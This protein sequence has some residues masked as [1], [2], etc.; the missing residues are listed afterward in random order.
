V[1]AKNG[2]LDTA[3]WRLGVPPALA[4]DKNLKRLSDPAYF[5]PNYGSVLDQATDLEIP[6]NAGL[7]PPVQHSIIQY[8][9][10]LPRD[11]A[12]FT[13]FLAVVASR[14]T[15]KTTTAALALSAKAM[16][17]PGTT[18]VTIADEQDRADVLFESVMYNYSRLPEAVRMPPINTTAVK[19]LRFPHG[20]SY[21]ALTSGFTGNTGLGRG[22]AWSHISEGPFHKNFAAFW[23]KYLP[24]VI[25]RKNA[26]VIVESTPGAMSEPSSPAY[27]ELMAEARQGLGRWAYVFAG[28]WTSR[29]NERPW[30]KD[31][32]L[33]LE[34]IRLLEL[35]GRKDGGSMSEPGNIHVMTLENLAFLREVRI[36][37]PEIRRDPS[38]LWV[39]YPK[40]DISCWHVVGN[41]AF[42]NHAMEALLVR[43]GGESSLIR[44]QPEDGMYQEYH[45]PRNDALY[46]IGVDPSGWGSGDPS[47]FQVLEV[48][49]DEVRQ[50]AE[51]DSNLL[52]PP[53]F[54]A[55]IIEVARYYNN[56]EVFVEN[57]GVGGAVLAVLE[58]AYDSKK[59]VN[60]FYYKKDRP[61]VPNTVPRHDEALAALVDASLDSRSGGRGTLVVR[62]VNLQAQLGTYR[63]DK[64]VQQGTKTLILKGTTTA[65]GRREKHHW[66]RVSALLWAMYGVQFQQSRTKPSFGPSR[67]VA[68]D[69]S[70][71]QAFRLGF[72]KHK[73]TYGALLTPKSKKRR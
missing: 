47:S 32:K 38:L 23:T 16:Y 19:H 8:C 25:N 24:A 73:K 9:S 57:N 56:A 72:S 14:Q 49:S 10:E 12:G 36:M 21:R 40:D 71:G 39:F 53:Q 51:F 43:S 59:L 50:V 7:C 27:R 48:W 18:G 35:Y 62:S 11:D 17:N 66:D 55:K 58:L 65:S 69:A 42:P 3:N 29:L 68:P 54:A 26:A 13:K 52:T 15:T 44:W 37:D 33:S 60:L 1:S 67:D 4:D 45:A 30:K 20:G 22:V 6:F 61:G 70:Q 34:E 63:Q 64:A 46:V 31:W 5:L 2:E 41:S 28:L